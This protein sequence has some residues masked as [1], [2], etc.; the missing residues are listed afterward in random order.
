[1]IN[2]IERCFSKDII[3]ANLIMLV[4]SGCATSSSFV[5]YPL[6]MQPIKE[7]I[8][9]GQFKVAEE[10]LNKHRRD[11]DKV[12]YMMERARVSQI[13]NDKI[14]SIED[15]KQVINIFETNDQKATISASATISQGASLFT[16]DNAIPYTGEAY[17]RVFV[18]HFQ[19]LNYLFND[20]VEKA[21][22]EVRRANDEQQFALELHEKEIA[23]AE[24]KIKQTAEMNENF[25]NSFS[26]LN[27]AANR[28]K[29]SFQNAYT[30]YASGIIYEA[31]GKY[32]DAYIDYKKALN[33]FPENKYLQRDI[34][35]LSKRIGIREDYERFR[36]IFSI[37]EETLS[38]AEGE[39][40]VFYEQGF[41]PV[42]L[43]IKIPL[44]TSNR[45]HSVAFPIYANAWQNTSPLTLSID[46]RT[47]LGQTTLG[48]TMPIVYVQSLAAKALQ[49]KLPSMMVRQILRLITKKQTSEASDK[50]FGEFGKLAA[51]IFNLISENADRR[52]WLTLP[53]DAQI[54]RGAVPLGEHKLVLKNGNI[55]GSMD[56]EVKAG[57]KTI[58]RAI[59]VGTTIHTEYVIL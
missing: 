8:Y 47:N 48:Q 49:E 10:V 9:N 44:F 40:I 16:N 12:L 38:G 14:T 21:L 13:A 27:D 51:D 59:S 4:L 22:V 15:F 28:V 34:L 52:S 17:E 37:K 24:H 39:I 54:F 50:L 3:T 26:A 32:N 56:I 36:K 58:I 30:F 42:K 31:A 18:Y 6:S 23:A 45:I 19:A 41:A 57:R 25:L 53:N 55:S 11:A 29:N 1:M 33:I 43:E 46:N 35:R 5:S 20:E 2:Y 7:Y